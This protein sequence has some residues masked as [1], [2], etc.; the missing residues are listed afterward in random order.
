VPY[1]NKKK[2]NVSK[3]GNRPTICTNQHGP[4]IRQTK[5]SSH[6]LTGLTYSTTNYSHVKKHTVEKRSNARCYL[7]LST[8]CS[9]SV[10]RDIRG[11]LIVGNLSWPCGLSGLCLYLV[12]SCGC[13]CWVPPHD[14]RPGALPVRHFFH[15]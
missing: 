11:Q 9:V 4:S 2:R 8:T 6:N 10:K 1:N 13:M 5:L 12:R 3:N 14:V 7:A 15:H